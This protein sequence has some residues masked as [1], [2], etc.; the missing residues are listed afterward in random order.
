MAFDG[1]VDFALF[2]FSFDLV[3]KG[4]LIDGQEGRHHVGSYRVHRL[5]RN[6][7]DRVISETLIPIGH[8]LRS[9]SPKKL[10]NHTP[11]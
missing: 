5:S 8:A 7:P 10:V 11:V 3:Q 6:V 1:L 9:A 2:G 4:S